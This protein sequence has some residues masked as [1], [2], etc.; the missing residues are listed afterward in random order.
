[1]RKLGGLVKLVLADES[2]MVGAL[3]TR[4][5]PWA[6]ARGN[7]WI[8][9]RGNLLHKRFSAGQNQLCHLAIGAQS[10]LMQASV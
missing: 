6:H 2:A 1:M 5:L 8:E 4:T 9:Q 10:V 7:R 3:Q